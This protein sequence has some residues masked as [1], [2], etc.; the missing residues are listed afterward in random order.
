MSLLYPERNETPGI[1]ASRRPVSSTTDDSSL[2]WLL[3]SLPPYPSNRSTPPRP[4]PLPPHSQNKNINIVS[5]S[6]FST[7]P[8]PA[9]GSRVLQKRYAET[10]NIRQYL[11]YT[12]IHFVLNHPKS[13]L[14]LQIRLPTHQY[15]SYT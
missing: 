5:A 14:F 7:Q 10:G 12:I 11:N 15:L 1:Q 2:H 6:F 3:R 13:P 4:L 8:D 9:C